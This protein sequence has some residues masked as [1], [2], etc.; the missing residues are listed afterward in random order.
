[1]QYTLVYLGSM[2]TL[3]VD[4]NENKSVNSS[5]TPF[6]LWILQWCFNNFTALNTALNFS[7]PDRVG[8]TLNHCQRMGLMDR[9]QP[10]K[11]R[12]VCDVIRKICEIVLTPLII[13]CI[14]QF[15]LKCSA[16]Y[17][18]FDVSRLGWG[19]DRI[20]EEGRQTEELDVRHGPRGLRRDST[21]SQT[22]SGGSSHYLCCPATSGRTW[23]QDAG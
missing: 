20:P 17:L 8:Y 3:S 19:V 1:M 7:N 2:R 6:V 14:W 9:V 10:K 5:N 11:L 23:G 21:L 22:T 16:V 15:S 4:S 12:K 13:Y 18:W